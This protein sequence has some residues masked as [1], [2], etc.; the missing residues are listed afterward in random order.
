M[1][2]LLYDRL[3]RQFQSAGEREAEGRRKGFSGKLEADLVRSEAK[4]EELSQQGP[5]DG[6][7]RGG[8]GEARPVRFEI[9]S[10]DVLEDGMGDEETAPITN[11]EDGLEVWREA[12]RKRF[13]QGRDGQFDY[14]IV[15]E[16]DEWDDWEAKTR[17]KQDEYFDG[18]EPEW[19]D[20]EKQVTGQTGIQ[21]F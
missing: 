8:D 16:N 21:D 5:D 13:M 15:D 6:Y 2:P 19:A 3:V 11:K 4:I 7:V 9:E 20:E 14:R 18:E 17:E 12:M 1:N 10:A